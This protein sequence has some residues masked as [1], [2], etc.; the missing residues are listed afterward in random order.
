MKNLMIHNKEQLLA[1]LVG[2]SISVAILIGINGSLSSN[3]AFVFPVALFVGILVC[4]VY[5]KKIIDRYG[6]LTN[7]L[8]L[9]I[10]TSF[11]GAA[12]LSLNVGF[13]SLFPYRILFIGIIFYMV[14]YGFLRNDVS[15]FLNKVSF[16]APLLLLI[17]WLLYA[18]L[19]LIWVD[20]VGSAIKGIVLLGFGIGL[21]FLMVYMIRSKQAFI[22][23]FY[24]WIFMA[25][26]LIAIGLA[27]HFF[28]I[29]LPISRI[30]LASAY[31]KMIPTSVFVNE[32]DFASFLSITFFLFLAWFNQT[33]NLLVK[34]ISIGLM[35]ISLYLIL[36]TSARANLL[37][38]FFGS[39][40][41]FVFI[42]RGTQKIKIIVLA[43]MMLGAGLAAFPEK[44]EKAIDPIINELSSLNVPADTSGGSVEIRLNLIKN[45]LYSVK[46][47]LGFGVGAGNAE[48]FME[49]EGVFPTY[50]D[51]NV[52][53][54]WIETLTNYGFIIF[55]LY[56]CLYFSIVYHLYYYWR[57]AR[58][59]NMKMLLEAFF[60]GMVVFSIASLGPSSIMGLNYHWLLIGLSICLINLNMLSNTESLTR[61]LRN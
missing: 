12:F 50:G 55:L 43:F 36:V 48:R 27:N 44:I 21:V 59:K 30:Y 25:V 39:F 17:I 18:I 56:S 60:M 5:K 38:I 32:N 2:T 47:T 10:A 46:E 61:R 54:W 29:H 41:W 7:L 24:I 20:S 35:I 26:F 15:I 28:Q 3:L 23:V 57:K 19:S 11:I 37:G 22:N 49:N 45:G 42:A 31:Q 1:L 13:F 52:H 34:A 14:L 51:Y 8:I 6:L 16:K 9:L 40:I 4:L 53:N 33:R 58:D